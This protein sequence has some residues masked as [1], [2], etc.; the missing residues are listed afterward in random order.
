MFGEKRG[1]ANS[2]RGNGRGR[3]R[4]NGRGNGRENGR[5]RGQLIVCFIFFNYIH[6]Y[7]FVFKTGILPL[8]HSSCNECNKQQTIK[9]TQY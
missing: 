7:F 2:A 6:Y 3:G 1:G 4:G 8:I 5:G 9:I